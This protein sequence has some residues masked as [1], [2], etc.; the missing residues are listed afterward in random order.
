M[1]L[2]L[3]HLNRKV[4]IIS[5]LHGCSECQPHNNDP[6]ENDGGNQKVNEFLVFPLSE[7]ILHS[8]LAIRKVNTSKNVQVQSQC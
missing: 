6:H 8:P 1:L 4:K 3:K 2:I 5:G 7:G